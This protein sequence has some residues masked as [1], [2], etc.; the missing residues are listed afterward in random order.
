MT[1]DEIRIAIAEA[2]GLSTKKEQL[3]GIFIYRDKSG[4]MQAALPN[5]PKDLNAMR[6]AEK[7]LNVFELT[8]YFSELRDI[9]F[10]NKNDAIIA[11]AK[12]RSYAFLRT[13]GKW[14]GQ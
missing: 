8:R 7:T 5:Y 9:C 11:T 6:E 13:L 3:G 2:C 14:S 1:D 12:E 4:N 10:A